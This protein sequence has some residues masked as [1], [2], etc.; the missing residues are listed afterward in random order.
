MPLHSDFVRKVIKQSPK[1][2]YAKRYE[3]YAIRND[4]EH[5]YIVYQRDWD[6]CPWEE[7]YRV[8]YEHID[9]KNKWKI[10]KGM[11]SAYRLEGKH[12]IGER[13]GL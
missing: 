2:Y 13:D 1:V 8:P 3:Y 11:F 7:I 5:E 9:D 6:E 4:K 12:R 10:A